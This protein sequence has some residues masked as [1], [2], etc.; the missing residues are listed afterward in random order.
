M[1]PITTSSSI[2]VNVST[3]LPLTLPTS[4][5]VNVPTLPVLPKTLRHRR[6][7]HPRPPSHL[8][9]IL[10]NRSRHLALHVFPSLNK[11]PTQSIVTKLAPRKPAST[12][13]APSSKSALKAPVVD[14]EVAEACCLPAAL[15]ATCSARRSLPLLVGS[16]VLARR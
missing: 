13:S 15:K 16:H 2:L 8:Y 9:L 7:R 12:T 6:R 11:F 10:T 5:L 4:S 3:F 14:Q 1:S